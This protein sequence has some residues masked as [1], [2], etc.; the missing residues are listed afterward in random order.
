MVWGMSVLGHVMGMLVLGHG[1]EY[2]GCSTGRHTCPKHCR[3]TSHLVD[4]DNAP[5]SAN[6]VGSKS[7]EAH[8]M[9]SE[10]LGRQGS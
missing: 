3:Y 8:R 2:A 5:Q 6:A 4:S 10:A 9:W 1:I 7:R